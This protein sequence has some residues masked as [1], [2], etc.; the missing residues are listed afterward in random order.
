MNACWL[1]DLRTKTSH[2]EQNV[3]IYID[4]KC[5]RERDLN[6]ESMLVVG[7]TW[8]VRAKLVCIFF[9]YIYLYSSCVYVCL[10]NLLRRLG[11][12]FKTFWLEAAGK[13]LSLCQH[14][15][16]CTKKEKT[17][18]TYKWTKKCVIHSFH[19]WYTD[20]YTHTIHTHIYT[21]WSFSV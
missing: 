14:I 5:E 2:L 17:K 21:Q 7:K 18:R 10:A 20:K 8:N 11:R 4:R 13:S 15:N 6:F 9:M 12:S 3:Q 19:A 16:A 1:V